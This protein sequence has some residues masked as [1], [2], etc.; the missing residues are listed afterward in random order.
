MGGWGFGE[1]VGVVGGVTGATRSGA[2]ALPAIDT[3]ERVANR[4]G[5]PV[6]EDRSRFAGSSGGSSPMVCGLLTVAGRYG[7]GRRRGVCRRPLVRCVR[8]GLFCGGY[9]LGHYET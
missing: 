6:F 8:W 1:V 2:C 4:Q 3:G 7:K 5:W 9:A